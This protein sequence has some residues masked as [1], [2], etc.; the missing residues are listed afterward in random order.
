ELRRHRA[1]SSHQIVV[2]LD[3]RKAANLMLPLHRDDREQLHLAAH[4]GNLDH[5]CQSS[6]SAA[7]DYDFRVRSHQFG[8]KFHRAAS[9]S[10]PEPMLIGCN[11]VFKNEYMVAAPTT[12]K[13]SP[14]AKQT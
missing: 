13:S 6:E 12:T 2:D 14:I 8:S 10:T 5:G 9:D 4:L 7:H 11:G 1:A 3:P